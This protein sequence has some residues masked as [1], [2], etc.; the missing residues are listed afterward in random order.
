M[1]HKK[2]NNTKDI[3]IDEIVKKVLENIEEPIGIKDIKEK[4]GKITIT[5]TNGKTKTFT[6]P[7]SQTFIANTGGQ[8]TDTSFAANKKISEIEGMYKEA[9]SENFVE[10]VYD[11]GNITNINI[12]NNQAK[13][14]ELF[15]KVIGYNN[16]N[17]E[18]V[19]ITDKTNGYE[20]LTT[21]SYDSSGNIS[22]KT[23]T[24]NGIN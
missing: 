1:I 4:N 18:S 19:V 7:K 12:Y 16:E 20:I 8:N 21:Y 13:N 10:Y 22:S 3:D 9:Y 14:I 6:L 24:L 17:I 2:E 11:N 23:K 15:T 5:L